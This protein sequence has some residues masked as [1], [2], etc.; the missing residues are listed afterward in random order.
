MRDSL[1]C[2][3]HANFSSPLRDRPLTHGTRHLADGI[4]FLDMRYRLVL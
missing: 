4:K 1:W 3:Q 2:K